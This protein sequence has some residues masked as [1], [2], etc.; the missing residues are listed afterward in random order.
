MIAT[1]SLGMNI[2]P[3]HQ[4]QPSHTVRKE[5]CQPWEEH[6]EDDKPDAVMLPE[7]HFSYPFVLRRQS[8]FM[9]I[10]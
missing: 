9:L 8:G 3:V 7:V 10:W 1:A 2:N 5:H 6:H 4:S